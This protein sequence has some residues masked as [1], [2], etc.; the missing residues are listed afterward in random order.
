MRRPIGPR[1]SVISAAAADQPGIFEYLKV[2]VER[3]TAHA[4]IFRQSILTRIAAA[5][6]GIQKVCQND[7][8]EPRAGREFC[9]PDGPAGGLMAHSITT[10]P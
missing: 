10:I 3:S 1:G 6:L 7:Q 4:A 8:D 2:G 9:L 5:I